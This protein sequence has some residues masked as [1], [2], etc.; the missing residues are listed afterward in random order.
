MGRCLELTLCTDS[1]RVKLSV[2][3][4]TLRLH[5]MRE[6]DVFEREDTADDTLELGF[7]D[8]RE[9]APETTMLLCIRIRAPEDRSVRRWE[10]ESHAMPFELERH[11]A[12]IALVDSS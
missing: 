12:A 2:R 6:E 7:D 11:H 4:V 3:L 1:H 9:R 5:K 10:N 8:E